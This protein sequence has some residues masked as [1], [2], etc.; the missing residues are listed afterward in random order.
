MAWLIFIYDRYASHQNAREQSDLIPPLSPSPPESRLFNLNSA[1][2]QRM[3]ASSLQSSKPH[4]SIIP[5]RTIIVCHKEIII[6]GR[7]HHPLRPINCSPFAINYLWAAVG[8]GTAAPKSVESQKHARCTLRDL[9]YSL[10]ILIS[11]AMEMR[12]TYTR[13]SISSCGKTLLN[14]KQ[15]RHPR[16]MHWIQFSDPSR[17]SCKSCSPRVEFGYINRTPSEAAHRP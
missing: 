1:A 10:E 7:A 13:L 12:W 8:A 11:H 2:S 15:S 17:C 16:Q 3:R 5:L 4:Q 9:I 6:I 14:N